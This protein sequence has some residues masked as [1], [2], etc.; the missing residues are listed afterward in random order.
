MK[1]YIIFAIYLFLIKHRKTTATKIAKEFEISTR[2]VYRYIDALSLMG[3]PVVTKLGRSGG[4]KLIKEFYIEGAMIRDDEKKIL[5]DFVLEN[6]NAE[7]AKKIISK[8]I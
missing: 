6:K 4:I 8:L 3:I 7:Q 5:K 2:S 1:N